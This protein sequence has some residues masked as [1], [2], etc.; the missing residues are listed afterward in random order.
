MCNAWNHAPGCN[1]GWGGDTGSGRGSGN[2]MNLSN[3]LPHPSSVFQTENNETY[4]TKCW[5]CGELVFYHTNGYGDCVLFDS[6]GYPWEIHSC[7]ATYWEEEK[8][9]RRIAKNTIFSIR[10]TI[11]QQKY[12]ILAGVIQKIQNNGD[13][14]TEESVGQFMEMAV[15][16]LQQA[17][18]MFYIISVLTLASGIEKRRLFLNKYRSNKN[19]GIVKIIPKAQEKQTKETEEKTFKQ[20]SNKRLIVQKSV[21]KEELLGLIQHYQKQRKDKH[22]RD[23]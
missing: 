21:S 3:S 19:S 18:G 14:V 17:Y 12:H 16:E 9:R 15:E 10:S 20:T 5:W 22:K 1:C 8:A 2:F 6:L 23:V 4:P 7:W 11:N 13:I